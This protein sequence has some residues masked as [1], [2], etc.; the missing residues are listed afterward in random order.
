MAEISVIGKSDMSSAR[1]CQGIDLLIIR[2]KLFAAIAGENRREICLE[3]GF[4]GRK[5]VSLA[6][7]TGKECT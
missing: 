4:R 7:A 5:S 1:S 6:L 2:H 3:P